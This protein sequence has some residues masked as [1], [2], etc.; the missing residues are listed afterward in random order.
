MSWSC[1]PG[2]GR[3]VHAGA[4][5]VPSRVGQPDSCDQP[6]LWAQGLL[7]QAG[8]DVDEPELGAAEQPQGAVTRHVTPGQAKVAV[9]AVAA[10]EPPAEIQ[11]VVVAARGDW[12]LPA[13]RWRVAGYRF[14][15]Q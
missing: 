6:V 7:D 1:R 2:E 3:R 4:D 15:S 11:A 9:G 8:I 13:C 5:R 12:H 14:G 10:D